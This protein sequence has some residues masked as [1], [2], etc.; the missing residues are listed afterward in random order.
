MTSRHDS[1]SENADFGR[2]RKLVKRVISVPKSEIDRRAEP[3]GHRHAVPDGGLQ[4]GGH[5]APIRGGA[6]WCAGPRSRSPVHLI[7]A[8]AAFVTA[9]Q[10]GLLLRM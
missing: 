9:L 4:V 7:R 6:V 2:F 5:G 10:I 1:D 3:R 8:S